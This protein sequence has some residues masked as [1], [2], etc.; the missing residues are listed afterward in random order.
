ML[1]LLVEVIIADITPLKWR[2]SASYIPTIPLI[3]N[4]WISGTV[5]ESVLKR[6]S[7]RWAMGM[8]G[9]ILAGMAKFENNLW[10]SMS[11]SSC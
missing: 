4:T 5:S 9:F 11:S 6:T 1:I 7:W 10:L 8:W 3:W 2:L